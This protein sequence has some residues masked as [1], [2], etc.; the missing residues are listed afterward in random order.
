MDEILWHF[1]G[2]IGWDEVFASGLV[3]NAVVA[4]GAESE[5][6]FGSGSIVGVLSWSAVA[7]SHQCVIVFL[8]KNMKRA[9]TPT[10]LRIQQLR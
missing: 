4:G 6:S 3:E 7:T 5:N 8:H 1:G 2:L 9:R 10:P